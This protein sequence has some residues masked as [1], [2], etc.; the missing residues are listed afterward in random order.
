MRRL[1]EEAEEEESGEV[2]WS[3]FLHTCLSYIIFLYTISYD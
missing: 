1:P 2:S 3:F